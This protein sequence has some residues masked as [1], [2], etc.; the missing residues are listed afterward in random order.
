MLPPQ[1]QPHPSYEVAE[2]SARGG[3]VYVYLHH[4]FQSWLIT[5]IAQGAF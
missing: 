3:C 1:P 4:R 2:T 5:G